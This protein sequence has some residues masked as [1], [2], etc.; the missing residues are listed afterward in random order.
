MFRT[1]QKLILTL[2]IM[3]LGIQG[4]SQN[5]Y[6]ITI[7]TFQK[8]EHPVGYSISSAISSGKFVYLKSFKA[9]KTTYFFDLDKKYFEANLDS[10]VVKGEIVQFFG[11]SGYFSVE[12][13]TDDEG[14]ANIICKL[15]YDDND[16]PIF[17]IEWIDRELDLVKGFFTGEMK[18]NK[19]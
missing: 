3:T 6:L 16:K 19:F 2:L 14:D 8:F 4:F 13:D 1:I 7:K 9:K 11:T 15:Y 10:R 12:V 5:K 17:T 18:F